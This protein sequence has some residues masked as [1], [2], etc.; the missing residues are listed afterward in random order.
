MKVSTFWHN[1]GK[2]HGKHNLTLKEV[3]VLESVLDCYILKLLK[4]FTEKV[5]LITQEGNPKPSWF[6]LLPRGPMAIT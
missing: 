5:T 1:R 3:R 6:T 2:L 4:L